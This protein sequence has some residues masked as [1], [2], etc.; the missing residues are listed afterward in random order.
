MK[1]LM[2]MMKS[3]FRR[4]T[5]APNFVM[6]I[7]STLMVFCFGSV[8]MVSTQTSVVAAFSNTLKY[9]NISYMLFLCSA[10]PYASSFCIDW[11]SHFTFSL[12]VR[13]SKASYTISKSV[14]NAIVGGMAVSIGS[15]LF[16]FILCFSQPN[17]L[18]DE[19]AIRM[20]FSNSAFGDLLLGQKSGLYFLAYLHV[21]FIQGTF[22]ASIGL[23]ASGYMPNK[24]IAVVSPFAVSFALNQVANILGLPIWLDPVKLATARIFGMPSKSVILMITLTFISLTIICSLLFAKAV[25]RRFEND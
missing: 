4:A 7:F 3:D 23:M 6:G 2:T 24:Y 1:N 21:I 19:Y 25:K 5:L 22:F 16:I 12:L 20:E 15:L 17:I 13:S 11:Q 10:V 14:V 9:N 8:G 18:P